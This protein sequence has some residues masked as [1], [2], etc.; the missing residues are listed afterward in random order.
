MSQWRSQEKVAIEKKLFLL[1]KVFIKQNE[2]SDYFRTIG[3]FSNT[4]Y[5]AV[6]EESI[7][8]KDACDRYSESFISL[9]K[10]YYLYL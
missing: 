5:Q 9:L 8:I 4:T 1:Q 3:V 6:T 7:T 2:E 10:D